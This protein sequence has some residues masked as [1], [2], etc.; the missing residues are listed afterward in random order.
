MENRKKEGIDWLTVASKIFCGAAL[1][2]FIYILIKYMLGTLMPFIIAY[3]FSL[4]I[5]PIASFL[6]KKAKI[7]KKLCAFI[8]LSLII[9]LLGVLLFFG[10]RRLVGEV[11]ALMESASR[12]E[13]GLIKLFDL[14]G[15]ALGK[16]R[17]K[18][19]LADKL[20]DASFGRISEEV[21]CSLSDAGEKLISSLI[22]GLGSFLKRII[23][24][25]PSFLIGVAVTVLS[26]YYFCVDK[27]NVNM[28]LKNLMP[29]KYKEGMLGFLIKLKGAAK[30]YAKA[31]LILMTLTFAEIFIGLL[32]LKVRY[33]FL[34]ALCI[35]AIDILPVLGAGIV[36]VPWAVCALLLG[37]T[38]VGLGLLVLYGVVTIMRQIA[39][40]RVIGSSMGIHPAAALFSSYV[41]IKLFGFLGIILGPAA[42][43]MISEI[44]NERRARN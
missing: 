42:A 1:V 32:L 27:E 3:A 25:T 35:A 16:L 11:S 23:S 29:S 30:K 8:S 17:E 28:G 20:S 7:P 31:Y 5:D 18:F 9:F 40:P 10:I 37:D 24:A 21:L 33:A 13:G 36:L 22:E 4:I 2:I 19:G 39:E 38:H 41:G 34:I 26:S 6:S 12:G 43:F 44:I 14:V 15:E